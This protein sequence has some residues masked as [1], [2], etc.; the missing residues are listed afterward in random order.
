MKQQFII[1]VIT[2]IAL[3]TAM[4]FLAFVEEHQVASGDDFWSVYFV[5]PLDKVDNSF[6][7]DN[8]GDERTFTYTLT[9]SD[10]THSDTITLAQ[11]QWRHITL[12]DQYN[13]VSSI[14]ITV[15]DTTTKKS[16]YKK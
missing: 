11:D 16:I 2:I 5:Q 9:T 14:T 8:H 10:V 15:D 7:I 4:L 1:I 3:V 13:N 6:I 12:P